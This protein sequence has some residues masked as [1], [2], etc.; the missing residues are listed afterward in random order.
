MYLCLCIL[1][2]GSSYLAFARRYL[3]LGIPV[4]SKLGDILA[5]QLANYLSICVSV[6]PSILHTGRGL[7]VGNLLLESA[8][9]W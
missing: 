9:W 7:R 2:C 8:S 1:L 4:T 3:G 6:C 5:S